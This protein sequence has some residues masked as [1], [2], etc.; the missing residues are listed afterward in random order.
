M[1]LLELIKDRCLC[2]FQF[3]SG[4]KTGCSRVSLRIIV[5]LFWRMLFKLFTIV[6]MLHTL[7]QL[8]ACDTQ[9]HRLDL[10]Q[11]GAQK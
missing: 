2:L 7:L 5:Y 4:I 10:V 6:Y 3:S 9:W 8:Y 1:K 11:V